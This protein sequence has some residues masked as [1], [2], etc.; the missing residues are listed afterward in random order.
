MLREGVDYSDT[1][2]PI[3]K[4]ASIRLLIAIAAFYKFRLVQLDVI[5]A[6][7]NRD[8][9]EQI[10]VQFPEGLTVPMH[11]QKNKNS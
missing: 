2:A 5:T 11:L 9:K 7:L 4:F 1:F 6:F 8:T 10:Y 3:A